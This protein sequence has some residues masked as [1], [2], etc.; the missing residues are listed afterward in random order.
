M[1]ASSIPAQSVPVPRIQSV[2]ALRGGHHDVDGDRS[3][4]R[5]RGPQCAAVLAY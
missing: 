5:L 2:D 4:S 3:H 1:A